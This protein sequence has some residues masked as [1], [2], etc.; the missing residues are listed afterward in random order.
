MCQVL[1]ITRGATPSNIAIEFERDASI[2][3][4]EILII[5]SDRNGVER[6]GVKVIATDNGK[7]MYVGKIQDIIDGVDI[8]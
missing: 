8:I 2:R 5:N 4:V 1:E 6:Q 3:A 7:I